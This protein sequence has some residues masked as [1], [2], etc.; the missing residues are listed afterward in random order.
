VCV[1]VRL[2]C[3][4]H[5]RGPPCRQ[6]I[7]LGWAMVPWGVLCTAFASVLHMYNPRAPPPTEAHMPLCHSEAL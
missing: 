4:V 5:P 7:T 2:A 6:L 1:W 3:A